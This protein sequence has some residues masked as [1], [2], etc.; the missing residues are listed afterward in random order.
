[1]KEQE[2]YY[3]ISVNPDGDVAIDM[4]DRD[5]LLD[6]L[7]NS[8]GLDVKFPDLDK[9]DTDPQYWPTG[10]DGA[11]VIIKGINIMPKAQQVV[12]KYDI[13]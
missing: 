8:Y 9:V 2:K 12:T 4:L 6:R 1:M 5:T 11:V 13:D 10:D 3:V 7:N